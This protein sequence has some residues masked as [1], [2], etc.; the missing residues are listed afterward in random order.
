MAT[1][2]VPR[3]P[4]TRRHSGAP[5]SP[6]LAVPGTRALLRLALRRDRIL[7][8]ALI[9]GFAGMV[10]VSVAATVGLYPDA[11]S[12]L[13]ASAALN[14]TA[15]LVALYG[16]VYEPTSLGAL[17]LIKLTGF[18][19]AAVA[20]AFVLLTVRHTRTEEESGRLELVTSGAVD[21]R[22][23]LLAACLYGLIGS[24]ALG[25]ATTAGLLAVGMEFPGSLA[26]G[27]SWTLSGLA[28]TAVAAVCA[29]VTVSHRAAIGLGLTAVAVAYA[30][31]AIGDL[32]AADPGWLSWLSPIGWSQ[33]LRPFAGD[34][35][36]VATLPL[37]LTALLVPV[38]FVLRSRRDLGSG[39]LKERTGPAHGR[40]RSTWGLA[41]RLQR[42]VLVAWV[43]GTCAMALV[44]GSAAPS[45]TGL[46][47]SAQMRE[48]V[49]LL[50]GE[51]GLVDA[52]LAAEIAILG[53]IIAGYAVGAV[54]RLQSEERSGRLELL[55]TP[56]RPRSA[57]AAAHLGFA[58]VAS[59][60]LIVVGG[61]AVGLGY[62]M[63][64]GDPWGAIVPM[65]AAAAAHVPAAWV[66]CGI[67]FAL[68][69]LHPRATPAV[70]VLLIGFVVLG[71]FGSLW[72]LPA[73]L[74]DVSPFAHSPT[75]PGGP[76]D[77]GG[78]VGLLVVAVVLCVVGL[79][80]W[81]RRDVRL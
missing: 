49:E 81:R 2:V 9:A 53:V 77:T 5:T 22:A 25:V 19:A 72:G 61:A 40:V 65:S 30:L 33:Q 26:F 7:L 29:Q 31:R 3:P 47:D 80:G 62:G 32:A 75:L 6:V 52:F 50:G 21:R 11:A 64:T 35:W 39:L 43:A 28:F 23:P 78:V 10:A 51:Q 17:S 4:S 13:Q 42:G 41:W 16:K 8:P 70:W 54:L 18:G 12:R 60:A 37:V 44:L 59:A 74:L 38:A 76:M 46:L 20:I 55:L 14:S 24:L 56:P 73:W 48:F 27:L 68:W 79:A 71:E 45:V 34:R 15:A 69:G 66:M 58:L 57:F 36:W 1:G 67:A 63:T